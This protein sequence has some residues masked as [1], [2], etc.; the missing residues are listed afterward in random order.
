VVQNVFNVVLLIASAVAPS[1]YLVSEKYQIAKKWDQANYL[2]VPPLFTISLYMVMFL[3]KLV[4]FLFLPESDFTVTKYG[5][6][7]IVTDLSSL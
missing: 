2:L 6:S 1:M 3:Y 5:E 4:R 7:S